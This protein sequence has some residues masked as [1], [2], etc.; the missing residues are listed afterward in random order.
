MEKRFI[1]L[2]I[3][4]TFAIALCADVQDLPDVEIS[5]PSLLRSLLEK[6]G[7]AGSDLLISDVVDSLH[8]LFP[9][10]PQQELPRYTW[11]MK[12]HTLHLNFNSLENLHATFLADLLFATPVA[13]KAGVNLSSPD[14]NWTHLSIRA[15]FH[16]QALNSDFT[17]LIK[18]LESEI[19]DPAY[20]LRKQ[21]LSAIDLNYNFMLNNLLKH[22]IS[23]RLNSQIQNRIADFSTSA[24]DTDK[25]NFLHQLG[26]YTPLSSVL[27]FGGAGWY[28][29]QNPVL[30]F[31][32]ALRESDQTEKW[33]FLRSV[34]LYI[35]N[36]RILP[37]I[38]FSQRFNLDSEN[39]FQLYQESALTVHENY[40]LQS[41]QPWQRQL[42]DPI[43]SFQ[44]LNAQLIY[45]NSN[46]SLFTHPVFFTLST[47][48]QYIFDEP[49]YL[50]AVEET[51]EL[52]L[53]TP[54]TV[55]KNIYRFGVTY[56]SGIVKLSQF[57]E[58]NKGWLKEHSDKEIP[59]LPFMTLASLVEL[60][61][62]P[63][64]LGA[65]LNQYYSA[66]DEQGNDVS[67]ALELDVEASYRLS[68]SFS[69]YLKGRNLLNQGRILY[70]TLPAEPVA[71]YGGLILS[72]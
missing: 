41:H 46:V 70:R 66:L 44:P 65:T 51:G 28:V 14:D 18:H 67:E 71:V 32:L 5:G 52:P 59:Y 30:S 11:R 7:L 58:L 54:E 2:I 8:P 15:G 47:G 23:V 27:T 26:F 3:C 50:A 16:Y 24:N 68:R 62:E 43:V 29:Y 61:P 49:V 34:S 48:V 63:F 12:K 31:S 25:L 6:R 57:V 35:S 4:L 22:P 72:F 53:L 10:F 21:S 9:P 69:L 19:S 37:G 56:N 36:D 13:F 60:N 55:F 40:A 42:E 64:R 45:T 38:H 39:S 1:L 20:D 17:V 33:D